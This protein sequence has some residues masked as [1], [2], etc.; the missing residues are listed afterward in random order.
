MDK[1]KILFLSDWS[2]AKTGFGRNAREVLLYLNDTGMYEI[3]EVACGKHKF[4]DN[5]F[6]SMPWKVYGAFPEKSYHIDTIKKSSANI[7]YGQFFIDDIMSDEKPDI[8][9]GVQDSW[10]FN[11]YP[12]KVW[13]NKIPCILWLTIDSLPL[14]KE[15]LKS[16]KYIEHFWVWSKF[17][18]KEL[19][20]KGF[21]HVKTV[22]G[23]IDA[24]TF[25][26]INKDTVAKLRKKT[27]VGDATVFGFVFRN[28][29]RKLAPPYLEAFKLFKDDNPDKNVKLYFHTSWHEGW[30]LVDFMDEFGIDHDDVLTTY[31]CKKCNH[32]SV[33]P[34]VGLKTKC[35][36]CGGDSVT[37]SSSH[38]P[39]NEQ[40]NA[41][42]NL[43]D[44]YIHPMTSGGLEMPIVE[45]MMAGIPVATVDYSCGS[46]YCENDFV[47]T[48]PHFE[49]R[50]LHT[51]FKKAYV[52]A[53]DIKNAMEHFVSLDDRQVSEISKKGIKWAS[54]NFD[55]KKV[56]E[57]IHD[58]L[59]SLEVTGYEF[60]ELDGNYNDKA[61][62]NDSDISDSEWAIDLIKSIFGKLADEND[63]RV[64]EIIKILSSNMKTRFEMYEA[65]ISQAMSHNEK[66][67]KSHISKVFSVSPNN[68]I[69]FIS[70]ENPNEK[71]FCREIVE[72]ISKEEEKPIII[73]G[74]DLDIAILSGVK[75][76]KLFLQPSERTTNTE[77]LL[78]LE[79]DG[80]HII[81]TVFY[82]NG[83][84]F[85]TAQH[86]KE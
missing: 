22:H 72:A 60:D 21:D 59:Q 30:N 76:V 36:E 1:K 73:V 15:V 70:P 74:N 12:E 50:E 13:W 10:A 58:Y 56:C 40:L 86:N 82:K 42:Y 6:E 49:Y 55:A 39:T 78:D 3:V 83:K 38:G 26:P 16:A 37:V 62:F 61:E 4:N 54:S 2:K 28:Q 84:Y 5:K 29:I 25:E 18:E 19:K 14:S 64:R 20:S 47:H 53:K 81:D 44:F 9:I 51:R 85:T 71:V 35:N 24:S 69:C 77:W 31:T 79:N 32:I 46:E 63:S 52:E 43:F 8:F 34:F 75:N 27:G 7:G 33:S 67:L 41:I 11:G 66:K 80:E 23:A 45:A 57:F 65:L 68:N 48:L 17:A